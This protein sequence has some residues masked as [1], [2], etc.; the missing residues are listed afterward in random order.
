MLPGKLIGWDAIDACHEPIWKSDA[1]CAS[2][3]K[4]PMA[5]PT[6]RP[7]PART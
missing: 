6:C 2:M 3:P 7:R 4:R 1:T 5:P